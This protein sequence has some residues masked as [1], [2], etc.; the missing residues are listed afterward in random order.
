MYLIYINFIDQSKGIKYFIYYH[1]KLLISF[2]N[3][4]FNY[5]EI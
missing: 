3:N 5:N 1:L 2:T 4:Y